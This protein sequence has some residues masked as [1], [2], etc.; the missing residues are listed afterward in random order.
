MAGG[1]S[2]ATAGPYDYADA[3]E[4][5]LPEPDRDAPEAWVRAGM[6]QAPAWV[7]WIISLL[8]D[9][10]EWRVVE[11]H[12]EV[13]QLEQDDPLMHAVLVGRRVGPSRRVMTTRSPLQA[14]GACTTRLGRGERGAS[15]SSPACHHE[16]G[17]DG[18]GG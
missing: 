11:S 14:A 10:D 13:V 9:D 2:E 16:H 7:N 18:D 8:P 3:F 4:V 15:T 17:F 12:N 1:S 5:R 6:E